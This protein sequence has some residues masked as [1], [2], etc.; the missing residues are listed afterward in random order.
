MKRTLILAAA[1][2]C[3]AGRVSAASV[4]LTVFLPEMEEAAKPNVTLRADGKMTV[5][6]PDKTTADQL[7]LLRGESNDV[8][9]ELHEA[10]D[11]V[12]IPKDGAGAVRY[13][14][15]AQEAAPCAPEEPVFGS[16]F[17]CEDLQPFSAGRYQTSRIVDESAEQ[18]V[19]AL[20]PK[21]SQ[22]S[23]VVITFDREKKVPLKTMYY[24]ETFN[25]LVK[26]R[27]DSDHVLVGRR[28]LPT[29]VTM[30]R[31]GLRSTTTLDLRW[32]QS[33]NVPPELFDRAYLSRTSNLTWPDLAAPAS[34]VSAKG[35]SNEE[36]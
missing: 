36:R 25:N 4:D 19:V 2:L 17:T 1:T 14:H 30:E 7:I 31:F 6:N 8:Y 16:D 3:L 22:Y 23:L 29:K 27:R 35:P 12:L 11:K 33:P 21:H 34:D 13:V 10:Q 15:G 18:V 20:F 5:V 9:V 26:M 24:Q 32:A 28:W